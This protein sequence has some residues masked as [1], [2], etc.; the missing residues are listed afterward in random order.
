LRRWVQ[1]FIDRRFYRSRYD[2]RKTLD[3]FGA[4]LRS[5]VEL[6]HLTNSL[7]QTVEQTMHPAHVS[8]WMREKAPPQPE[9]NQ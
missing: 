1:G 3:Q 5:E 2:T 8:L 4:S 9:N 6:A 7:L